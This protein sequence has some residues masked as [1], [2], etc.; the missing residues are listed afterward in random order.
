MVI[1]EI[2][3]FQQMVIKEMRNKGVEH[4]VEVIMIMVRPLVWPTMEVT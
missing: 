2:K 4:M 1:K 3:V